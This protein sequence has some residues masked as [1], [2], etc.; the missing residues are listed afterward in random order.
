MKKSFLVLGGMS[1]ALLAAILM[2]EDTKTMTQPPAPPPAGP[3]YPPPTTSVTA[4]TSYIPDAFFDGIVALA[5]DFKARG[6]AVTPDDFLAVFNAESGYTLKNLHG[7]NAYGYGGLNGMGQAAVNEVGFKGTV[8]DYVKQDIVQQLHYADI[9]LHNK[10]KQFVGNDYTKVTDG[11]RL[12][13]SNIFPAF[14]GKPLDFVIA[15]RTSDPHGWYKA[16]AGIDG[17]RKG[18]INV[19]DMQKFINR[20]AL[21]RGEFFGEMRYRAAQAAARAAQPTIS[22][23]PVAEG[24]TDDGDDTCTD[25]T[26][27]S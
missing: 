19:A 26:G 1:A 6:A 21:Q 20:L 17:D 10:V 13:C 23:D 14:M 27:E 2:K 18:Y 16:N 12:Y 22:A 9:F 8:D 7:K 24:D 25:G 3:N 11:G 4:L 15:G 5:N